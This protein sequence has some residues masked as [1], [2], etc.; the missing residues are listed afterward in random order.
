MRKF[1]GTIETNVIGS[2]CEFEFEVEDNA[3]EDEIEEE[4]KETAFNF[5]NW[6]YQEVKSRD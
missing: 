2:A 5:I 6:Q 1:K 4:A 3:T